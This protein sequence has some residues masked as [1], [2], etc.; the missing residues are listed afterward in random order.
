MDRTM[1]TLLDG[2]MGYEL[3]LRGVKVP[4]HLDSIWSAQALFDDPE[5]VVRVH[6]D[7]IE[8]GA[9]ILTI[10]NYAVT[11]QLLARAGMEDRVEELTIRAVELAEKACD[12]AGR[13]SRIAGS[14][15]PL[16]TTYRTDLIKGQNETLDSYRQIAEVLADRVDLFLCE[17]LASSQEAVWAATVA[18]ETGC[19]YWVSWTLQGDRP[20]TLP[21]G[22]GIDDAFEA[23]GDLSPSSYLV[24]CCGAKLQSTNI[25]S[26]TKIIGTTIQI[27]DTTYSQKFVYT[28]AKVI[29]NSTNKRENYT[30]INKG[31]INGIEA[32]MGVISPKGVIGTVK[33]VSENF[34]SVMSVLHEKNSISVKIKNSDYIGALTWNSEDYRTGQLDDIPNHV[35]LHIGDTL[36]TSGYSLIYPEGVVVGWIKDFNLPEGNNFYNIDVTYS[37]DY[38]KITHVFIIK[39]WLK[40]EQQQLEALNKTEKHD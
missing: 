26:F 14:L 36:I 15:P 25:K 16:E 37:A 11:P 29:N 18:S 39:S 3:M 5:A 31:A 4:S 22:E 27:D 33:N 2:G 20:D 35:K 21:S 38:K 9:D 13:R 30:T 10:N 7:F 6:A 8:A 34:S 17:T 12:V 19:E 23:L 1:V 28:S 40:E 32:G 24:N